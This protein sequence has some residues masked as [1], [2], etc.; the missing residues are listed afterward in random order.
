MRCTCLQD[1]YSQTRPEDKEMK[2]KGKK[3]EKRFIHL[4]F[5]SQEIYACILRKTT[6]KFADRPDTRPHH[7]F[8][9]IS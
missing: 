4:H 8:S 1:G 6:D 7:L 2:K 9:E 5:K 3:K